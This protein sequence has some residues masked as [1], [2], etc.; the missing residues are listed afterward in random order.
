M[1]K[2]LN[3]ILCKIKKL[4]QIINTAVKHHNFDQRKTEY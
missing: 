3:L 4:I 1:F 2:L